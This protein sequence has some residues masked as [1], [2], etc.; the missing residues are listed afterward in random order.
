MEM[1]YIIGDENLIISER[2]N[3]I[4]SC[5]TRS[6][7]KHVMSWYKLPFMSLFC[8]TQG[9]KP[10]ASH[11]CVVNGRSVNNAMISNLSDSIQSC[12]ITRL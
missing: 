9:I 1:S 12:S 7:D 10:V 2:V 5:K 4:M 6:Q 8:K 3:N 11:L